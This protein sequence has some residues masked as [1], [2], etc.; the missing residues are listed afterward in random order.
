MTE[1]EKTKKGYSFPDHSWGSCMD[2][3]ECSGFARRYDRGKFCDR[4]GLGCDERYTGKRDSI[5]ESL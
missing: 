5:W 4:G 3:G 1:Q 2:W